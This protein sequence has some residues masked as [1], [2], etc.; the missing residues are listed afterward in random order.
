MKRRIY[1]ALAVARRYANTPEGEKRIVLTL[2]IM[3]VVLAADVAGLIIGE[4][5][6]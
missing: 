3:S 5:M 2:T 4:L 6:R 1:Y